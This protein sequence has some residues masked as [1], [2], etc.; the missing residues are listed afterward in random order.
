MTTDGSPSA[1]REALSTEQIQ[2]VANRV[3]A[4]ERQATAIEASL[5]ASLWIRRVLVLGFVAFLCVFGYLFYRLAADFQKKENLDQLVA[6]FQQRLEETTLD[7]LQREVRSLV[8]TAQPVLTEAF[9]AQAKKDE[10][11]YAAALEQEREVFLQNLQQR[12]QD[13]LN[14]RYHGILDEHRAVLKEEFPNLT[15]EQLGLMAENIQKA[16]EQLIQKYYVDRMHDELEDMFA[17]WDEFPVAD[18]VGPNDIPLE[19]QLIGTL[20]EVLTMKLTGSGSDGGLIESG[21]PQ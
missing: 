15:D 3:E 16:A 1:Q 13:Q 11:K 4:V 21:I 8:D 5:S 12:L 14:E 10:S 9:T 7:K 6:K 19:D 2:A 20:L 18:P 17:I